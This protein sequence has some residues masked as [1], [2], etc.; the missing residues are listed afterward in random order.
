VVAILFA[1]FFGGGSDIVCIIFAE[2]GSKY[3]LSLKISMNSPGI[4]HL[5]SLKIADALLTLVLIMRQ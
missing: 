2:K 1:S 5:T 3:T 4:I